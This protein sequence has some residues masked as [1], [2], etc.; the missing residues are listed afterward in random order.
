MF[1][2]NSDNCFEM[3]H[4]SN[5]EHSLRGWP[6]TPDE[7]H[8]C[9]SDVA[10]EVK[11]CVGVGGAERDER[12][13]SLLRTYCNVHAHAEAPLPAQDRPRVIWAS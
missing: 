5:L 9:L 8:L 11:S 3:S 12:V 13:F 4:P 6:I 10:D 2:F 1:S 7:Y